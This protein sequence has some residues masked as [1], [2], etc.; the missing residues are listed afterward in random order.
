M[1]TPTTV[2]Q[3]T[4]LAE[5][6]TLPT[7]GG[8]TNDVVKDTT[9]APGSTAVDSAKVKYD[10]K[11]ANAAKAAL[12]NVQQG[13]DDS[14]L[15]RR[16]T[17][18]AKSRFPF[19]RLPPE[20]RNRVYK[21]ALKSSGRCDIKTFK[22]PPLLKVCQQ[23]RNEASGLLTAIDGFDLNVRTNYVPLA[24]DKKT[25]LFTPVPS[26]SIGLIQ[27]DKG[28]REWLSGGKIVFRDIHISV[29]GAHTGRNHIGMFGI[30]GQINRWEYVV[31]AQVVPIVPFI[32][33]AN[34]QRA[35]EMFADIKAGIEE[36]MNE[37]GSAGLTFSDLEKIAKLFDYV[38]GE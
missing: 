11:L 23:I 10:R 35:E 31:H 5:L 25:P 3:T 29:Y 9:S 14:K 7:N 4:E 17:R 2:S 18:Y 30:G 8:Q 33:V 24:E 1:D 27:L 19:L 21:L 36:V 34:R 13:H 37:G 15:S 6:N 28:R 26:N 20:V 16:K 12:H 38:K 22:L 32:S